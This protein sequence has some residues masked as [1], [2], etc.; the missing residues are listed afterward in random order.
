MH[1]IL[2]FSIQ[3][4]FSRKN[5]LRLIRH[6][7][8]LYIVGHFLKTVIIVRKM[9]KCETD[10]FQ[11]KHLLKSKE[12]DMAVKKLKEPFGV[13]LLNEYAVDMTLNWLC[14]TNN[15]SDVHKNTLF[16][17]LDYKAREELLKF[18]PE[19]VVFTWN[20]KC[21]QVRLLFV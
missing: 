14:N 11:L 17:T 13:I 21:L 5:F 16:V 7:F 1:L 2:N 3:N 8:F 18:Y 4:Y 9:N 10:E 6:L 19:L 15:M 20:A 12:F